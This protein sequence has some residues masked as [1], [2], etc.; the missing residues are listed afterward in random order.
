M[1]KLLIFHSTVAPYRID[2]FNDLYNA[3]ESV[4]CLRYRNLRSQK[5]DYDKIYSQFKFKPVYLKEILKIGRRS[6]NVGYWKYLNR[7]KPDIVL[8]EEFSLATVLVFIHRLFSR[9]K[10]KIVTICDDSYNMVAEDNDFS[11]LQADAMRILQ[12]ESELDEIVRL[13]GMDALS[14]K[15]RLTMEAAKSIREDYLHQDAFHEV[16][17]ATSLEKQYK[18]LK[19]ILDC[20]NLGISAL[21][22]DVELDDILNMPVREKIG[23]SKY[24]PETEM[25]KFDEIARELKKSIS[26]LADKGGR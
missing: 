13:V 22:S 21:N 24:I 1:K 11:K 20:Y 12:E 18:M 16:D 15:D 23:R 25:N 19:L 7:F 4:I 8:T 17:T 14:Y 9:R 10:Y 5:F 2:F 26:D 3:F 6:F